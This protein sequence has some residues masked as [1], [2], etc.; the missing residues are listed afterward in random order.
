[1]YEKAT[2]TTLSQDVVS[3]ICTMI[4]DGNVKKGEHL[5]SESRLCS[6]FGVSRTT[7][8]HALQDLAEQEIIRKEKGKASLVISDNFIYLN[9][10]LRSKIRQYEGDLHYALEVRSMLEPQIAYKAALCATKQDLLEL[11]AIND[12]CREKSALGTITADDLRLFH[13]RVAD[14]LKNPALV[15]I[16]E[17]LISLCDPP[18]DMLLDIPN[19]DENVI[20]ELIQEHQEILNAI[21]S[22]S[23]EDA[24]F[25]M[26][27]DIRTYEAN[28]FNKLD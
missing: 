25:L 14:I 26:R 23:P 19:P 2:S 21:V 28:C 3:Q 8:R 16:L 12:K 15:S 13:L 4:L 1:M 9:E 27:Q 6:M 22:R 10:G 17:E 7:V 24:Y 18:L 11:Q 5:P 20:P